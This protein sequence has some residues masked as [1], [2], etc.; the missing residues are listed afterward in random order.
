MHGILFKAQQWEVPCLLTNQ[1]LNLHL[2]F[3]T[4]TLLSAREHSQG[5][6][7]VN[8]VRLKNELSS[9]SGVTYRKKIDHRPGVSVLFFFRIECH[10]FFYVRVH[11]RT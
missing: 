7:N 3:Y 6:I 1:M 10:G 4:W 9:T 11:V 5:Y 2:H 8:E